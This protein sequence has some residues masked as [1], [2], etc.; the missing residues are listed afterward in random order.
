MKIVLFQNDLIW[1]FF[2]QKEYFI[3]KNYFLTKLW[4]F[5]QNYDSNDISSTKL[6]NRNDFQ[7]QQKKNAND[8]S[9]NERQIQFIFRNLLS[10]ADVHSDNSEEK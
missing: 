5:Q 2:F 3:H 9:N 1:G 4:I 10:L 6:Q 8:N 7:L